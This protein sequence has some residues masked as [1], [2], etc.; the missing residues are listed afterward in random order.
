MSCLRPHA[1]S[2]E[3]TRPRDEVVGDDD[4]HRELVLLG[5]STR[6][7]S[8]ARALWARNSISRGSGV[9]VGPESPGGG[10]GSVSSDRAVYRGVPSRGSVDRTQRL[11]SVT[12]RAPIRITAESWQN[13]SAMSAPHS[14]G[15]M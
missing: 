5:L 2:G 7:T 3:S 11:P 12:T 13:S 8:A 6:L 4:L 10:F 9:P 1:I 14:P 15:S